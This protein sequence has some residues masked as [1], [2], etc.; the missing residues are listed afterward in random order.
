MAK[1]GYGDTKIVHTKYAYVIYG[2]TIIGRLLNVEFIIDKDV[3]YDVIIGSGGK[4]FGNPILKKTTFTGSFERGMFINNE[5][6]RELM[7]DSI[8]NQHSDRDEENDPR[9]FSSADVT[10]YIDDDN[11]SLVIIP[12]YTTNQAFAIAFGGVVLKRTKLLFKNNSFATVSSEFIGKFMEYRNKITST[13]F[14]DLTGIEPEVEGVIPKP[15]GYTKQLPS[16]P[17][18]FRRRITGT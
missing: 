2:S 17:S 12:A 10:K 11:T 15:L 14:R 16:S 7:R 13:G 5:L 8:G 6:E 4:P 1:F 9:S 18:E 3:E